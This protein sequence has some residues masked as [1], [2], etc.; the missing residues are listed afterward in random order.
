MSGPLAEAAEVVVVGG[1]PAG[2]SATLNLARALVDVTLVDASRP[3]NSATLRSH[4]FLTRDG[5]RPTELRKI[6]RD[7]LAVYENVRHL[8]RVHVATITRDEGGFLIEF[9]VRPG[10]PEP[11]RAQAVLLAS[12]LT[13]TLPQ[14]PSIRAFYGMSVYSCVACDAWD[15]RDK[16]LALIGET[17]DLGRRALQLR[18]WT[19]E[20]TVF[21]NGA[22]VVTD[23][24]ARLLADAGIA[25]E[26]GALADL[27]GDKGQVTGVRLVDGRAVPI[28]GGFVRPQWQL[29]TGF[30][31]GVEPELAADGFLAVDGS[32]RTS[33]PGLY[34]AGDLTSPGPQQM[35]IAAGHGA[36]VAAAIADDL[37]PALSLSPDAALNR[38]SHQAALSL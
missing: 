28:D 7:E 33:V 27:E 22:G 9:A 4:G 25:L 31:G 23:A 14:L 11:I 8:D 29:T 36:R 3:R 24:E 20:L 12:G 19:G 34:A 6:A 15:L 38:W 35:I 30:L 26:R 10:A 21:T 17:S 18:R 32:G 2:L 5:I 1:G 37:N 16:R 13:E